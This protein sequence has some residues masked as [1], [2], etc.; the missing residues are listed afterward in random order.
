[1]QGSRAPYMR[2]WAILRRL[3]RGDQNF[4][5]EHQNCTTVEHQNC[6]SVLPPLRRSPPLMI[7]WPV[8][9]QDTA[10]RKRNRSGTVNQG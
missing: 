8:G 9:L 7:E 3:S 6:E 10:L 5:L 4:T 2:I 1:M